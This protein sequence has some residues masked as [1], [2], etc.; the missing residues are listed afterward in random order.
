MMSK[1]EDFGISDVAKIISE[2]EKRLSETLLMSRTLPRVAF[3]KV[4]C[5]TALPPPF[6]LFFF[7]LTVSS[8]WDWNFMGCWVAP[9]SSHNLAAENIIGI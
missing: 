8:G 3:V 7:F 6:F 5:G 9:L 1:F 4:T 2:H